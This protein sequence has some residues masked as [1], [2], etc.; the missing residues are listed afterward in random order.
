MLYYLKYV[1]NESARADCTTLFGGMSEEDDLRDMGPD[2]QLVGRWSTVGESS[3]FCI[4]KATS[5]KAMNSWL[6]NWSS[7]ATIECYPVVDDNM[8]RK[9]ILKEEPSFTVDY[10]NAGSEA[11]EGESLFF[12]EYKFQNGKRQEGYTAFSKMSEADDKQDAGSNTCFGRWHN[13]GTGSG[14]AI[15][16]S[17]SEEDLYSWAFNWTSMCDCVIR[18]VVTD[19]ECRDN[20]KSKPDF[21]SKYA[22]LMEKM[23][24]G[25]KSS[26]SWFFR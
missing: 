11:K 24:G 19:K 26:S 3:G 4:C 6:L 10:S 22:A 14:V 13:L 2:I 21:A 18:P 1:I 16:S 8:A 20:I 17:K 12:V 7:M 23:K 5:A 15:C 25:K 9:I